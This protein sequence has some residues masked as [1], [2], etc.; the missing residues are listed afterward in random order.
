[1]NDCW[2][3]NPIAISNN[4]SVTITRRGFLK[5]LAGEGKFFYTKYCPICHKPLNRR[6]NQ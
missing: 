5:I 2:Y 3:C 1:M 6:N 4:G